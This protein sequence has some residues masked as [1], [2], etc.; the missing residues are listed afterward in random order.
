MAG[1]PPAPE[2]PRPRRVWL[3]PET[4]PSWIRRTFSIIAPVVL[5][6]GGAWVALIVAGTTHSYVGPLAVDVAFEPSLSGE[7]I[8]HL[9]PVGAVVLDTHSGP[10]TLNISVR[11]LDLDG[12]SGIVSDPYSLTELDD[13]VVSGL[14]DL[15]ID[16]AIRSAIIAVIGGTLGAALVLRSVRR[17][18]LAFGVTVA[19]LV[20]TA[21]LAAITFD[22]EAVREPTYAGPLTA[23]PQLIGNAEDIATNFDAYAE[24][25]AGFVTNVARVY[26]TTLSLDTFQPADDTIRVLHVSDLHL[27]PAAWGIIGSVAEQYDVDVIVDSGDIVDQGSP[28]ENAY[29]RSIRTLSGYPYVFVKGNHDSAATAAAVAAEPNAVVLDGEP[30]EVAGLRFVGAPDPRFT[31]DKSVRGVP[32]DTIRLGTEELADAVDELD[33]PPDVVVYHDPSH[34]ELFDGI[35]PLVLSGHMHQRDT[36]TLDEGTRVMVQ[37]S[38]GGA[39]LRGLRNE[40]PTP[41]ELSVLYFDPDDRQLVAWDDLTLGGLGQTSAQIDRHQAEAD[42]AAKSPETPS[43]SQ[44]LEN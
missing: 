36:Y 26:N 28:A 22:R 25:L 17:T 6:L 18:L 38:T 2:P 11:Q 41:V 19:A 24:Q 39:G 12:L 21:G 35:T 27:N 43:P 14:Q 5:A 9:D 32:D 15:I 10:V 31:P 4:W 1:G 23:A 37:G 44:D 34:V 13:Q 30:V 42:V 20:G 16:A 7:S 8:I 3:R 33:P 40:E 29:V